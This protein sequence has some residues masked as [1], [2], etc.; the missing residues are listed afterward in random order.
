MRMTVPDR[1]QPGPGSARLPQPGPGVRVPVPRYRIPTYDGVD[2][3]ERIARPSSA[4]MATEPPQTSSF[5][6]LYA[7]P[8]SPLSDGPRFRRRLATVVSQY[9]FRSFEARTNLGHFMASQFG[10]GVLY[11]E[12]LSGRGFQFEDHFLK[13]QIHDVLESITAITR[14]LASGPG[15]SSASDHWVRTVR[16]ILAEEH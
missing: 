7:R 10:I 16:R 14:F 9:L 8:D 2:V 4:A 15:R 11:Y 12:G 13:A 5:S 1:S 3:R 6:R